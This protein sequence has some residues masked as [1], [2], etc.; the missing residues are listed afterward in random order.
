MGAGWLCHQ[1][2]HQSYHR[3][4]STLQAR[5]RWKPTWA[6]VVIHTIFAPMSAETRCSHKRSDYV[7]MTLL[8][9]TKQHQKIKDRCSWSRAFLLT[10]PTKT[11]KIIIQ[12]Q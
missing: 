7:R 10:H 11:S 2:L 12:H 1:H 8:L 5:I 9:V 3:P 4:T 6:C